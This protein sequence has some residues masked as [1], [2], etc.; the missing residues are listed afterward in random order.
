[1]D[2]DAFTR[3]FLLDKTLSFEDILEDPRATPEEWEVEWD[4]E[5]KDQF[6]NLKKELELMEEIRKR[7]EPIK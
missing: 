3:L 2:K 5:I 1:M 7:A 4:T 6:Y